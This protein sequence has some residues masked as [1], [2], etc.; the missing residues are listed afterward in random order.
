MWH[1][2]AALKPKE[3]WFLTILLA[4]ATLS[5]SLSVHQARWVDGTAFLVPLSLVALLMGRWLGASAVSRRVSMALG[6]LAGVAWVFVAVAGLVPPASLL[7]SDLGGLRIWLGDV[8]ARRTPQE[9]PLAASWSYVARQASDL[10]A[11]LGRWVEAGLGGG[12]HG[13]QETFLLLV[14]LSLWSASF[15]AGWELLRTRRAVVALIPLGLALGINSA[16]VLRPD[17]VLTFLACAVLL[18][19]QGYF[20]ALTAHWERRGTDYSPEIR[21][22]MALHSFWIAAVIVVAAWSFPFV[23]SRRTAEL[24]WRP[25]AGPWQRAAARIAPLF[26]GVRTAGAGGSPANASF[27][28][29]P[30]SHVLGGPPELRSQVVMTVSTSDPPPAAESNL[31]ALDESPEHEPYWRGV[32]YDRYTGHGWENTIARDRRLRANQPLGEPKSRGHRLEQHYQLLAPV[33][34]V[35]YAVNRP[36]SFDQPVVVQ[37]REGSDVVAILSSAPHYS[38]VSQV[39]R[40]SEAQLREAPTHYPPEIRERYLQLPE[41]PLRVRRLAEKVVADAV[42]PYDKARALETYLRAMPYDLEVPL[43]PADQDVV[44]YFL[45]DLQRGY[46]DYFATAMVVMARSVGVPARLATGYATG[47]Y[48]P[49]A[50]HYVVVGLNAH[51][52]PE[53]YV[54]GQGWIEFE[55]TPAYPL[56]PWPE[57][58]P[59]VTEALREATSRQES[60]GWTAALTLNARAAVRVAGVVAGL[61]LVTWLAVRSRDRSQSPTEQVQAVYNRL[62]GVAARL[63]WGPQPGETP[64]EYAAA[65]GRA[66]GRRVAGTTFLHWFYHLHAGEATADADRVAQ[67]YVKARYS[68]HPVTEDE[69]RQVLAAWRRLRNRLPFLLIGRDASSFD[70]EMEKGG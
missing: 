33:G 1:M 61:V 32:S 8:A 34:R 58:L 4:A 27:G 25:I 3:G 66:L 50:G 65:L 51:A 20:L 16:Y 10:T 2:L 40:A 26:A 60:G 24:L 63:G 21:L 12:K 67:V 38:V 68:R 47:R 41:V 13:G 14:A 62:C 56:F 7:A 70:S 15:F 57:S 52:W 59:D 43:P 28:D 39:P 35:R 6:V 69:R 11:N 29:L 9:V 31:V 18:L 23:A 48:D 53:M 17:L 44:D 64:L 55:P 46:C 5:V 19:V 42:T 54:P 37:E 49:E 30:L 45:F 22:D 36:V